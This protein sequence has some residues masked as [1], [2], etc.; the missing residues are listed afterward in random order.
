M[1]TQ[2][3]YYIHDN[4]AK[5]FEVIVNNNSVGIRKGR[6]I[7]ND[8]FER[9]Y[10]HV[11]TI[12]NPLK[13]FIGKDVRY[14]KI[15]HYIEHDAE[16]KE[17]INLGV[18]RPRESQAHE[19]S[20]E[21][22]ND[23]YDGNTILIQTEKNMFI[24]IQRDIEEYIIDDTILDYYS[25]IGNN[26]VPYPYAIGEKNIY[27]FTLYGKYI[28]KSKIRYMNDPNY[29]YLTLIWSLDI[30]PYVKSQKELKDSGKEYNKKTEDYESLF[31]RKNFV[32]G[33]EYIIAIWKYF[34]DKDYEEKIKKLSEWKTLEKK[35]IIE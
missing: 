35:I 26:D 25:P 32:D 21:Y 19:E 2:N 29:D 1:T 30:Y 18:E 31:D 33:D 11:L 9:E 5:S 23:K 13:V 22:Y 34:N 27:L 24:Y 15:N 20:K 7:N 12:H 8:T 16:I 6:Y 10:N 28:E 4:R 3:V 17:K 14:N